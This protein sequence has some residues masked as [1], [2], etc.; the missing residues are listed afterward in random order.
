MGPKR[1]C[2]IEARGDFVE[3]EQHPA[4][5]AEAAHFAQILR[6]V[7]VHRVRRLED[8]LADD[9]GDFAAV[10]V[11][12]AAKRLRVSVIPLA[13]C[14][15]GRLLRKEVL[16]HYP[17]EERVHSVGV[18]ERH[19]ERGIT[20]VTAL[21]RE[22]SVALWVPERVLVLNG[23]L[24]GDF[25]GDRPGVREEHAIKTMRRNRRELFCE[26]NGGIMGEAAEHHVAHLLRLTTYRLD[27]CRV[28]VAMRDAP[29]ARHRV[30]EPRTV[31][32][33]DL[34]A[35]R[36]FRVQDWRRILE[37]GVGVPDPCAIIFKR[38]HLKISEKSTSGYGPPM[39][40]RGM[41]TTTGENPQ[42]ER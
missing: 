26:F 2:A 34:H 15:D 32:K 13:P 3:D 35:G 23:H 16:R 10:L 28:V 8:W 31:G 40:K 24:R 20:V 4:L 17:L 42:R 7:E 36:R 29:P 19:R 14:R 12:Y 39:S 11:D 5:V 21:Q 30:D 25:H 18:G 37:R 41:R 38:R 9:R 27:D 22:K 33:F 6:V 1:A